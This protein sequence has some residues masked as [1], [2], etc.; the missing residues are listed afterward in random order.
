MTWNAN[1]AR[2]VSLQKIMKYMRKNK[3]L[4]SGFQTCF[5]W[6]PRHQR[7]WDPI[8]KHISNTRF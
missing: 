8:A 7:C 1:A 4:D 3:L 6:D 2:T 5:G